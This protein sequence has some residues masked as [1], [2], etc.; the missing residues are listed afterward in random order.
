MTIYAKHFKRP[1]D[2]LAATA[3]LVA[4][5]PLLITIGLVV[6]VTSPGPV[7]FRQIR[8]GRNGQLFTILKFRTMKV[9]AIDLR[10]SDGTTFNGHD[11]QRVTSVGH[12][13][14]LTSLDELPQLVNVVRGEMSLVGGRPDLPDGVLGYRP[15]QLARLKVRPGLTSWAMLHGRNNVPVDQRRDL[16]AW[17]AYNITFALDLQILLRTVRI[18]L[19]RE[20]VVND[21]SRSLSTKVESDKTSADPP[22]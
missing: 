22:S 2:A 1:L 9:D 10:N 21:Y 14:R 3:A 8:V 15:H 13:L 7:I 4:L 5:A 18:V 19:K 11:D 17:Y 12:F 20:G 6:K 16:D